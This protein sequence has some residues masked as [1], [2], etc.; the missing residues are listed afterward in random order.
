M[1]NKKDPK[2]LLIELLEAQ[3]TDLA[4]MS[5]I[6]LGDDVITRIRELKRSARKSGW[7][8]GWD[9]IKWP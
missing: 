3:I 6:E 4:L 2:D 5:K 8:L 7:F 9:N 1:N